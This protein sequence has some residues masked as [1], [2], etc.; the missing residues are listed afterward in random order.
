MIIK[1]RKSI[2]WKTAFIMVVF[3][4]LA[5]YGAI[6]QYSSYKKNLAKQLK[7]SEEKLYAEKKIKPDWNN[8][9]LKPLVVA[10]PQPQ[11]INENQSTPSENKIKNLITDSVNESLVSINNNIKNVVEKEIKK[12]ENPLVKKEP[13]E[14]KNQSN[15]MV[16]KKDAP[17]KRV[18]TN[19]PTIKPT[20]QP[21]PVVKNSNNFKV[22]ES[23]RVTQTPIIQPQSPRVTQTPI[24]QP[25]SPRVTQTPIIQESPRQTKVRNIV[26]DTDGTVIETTEE[27]STVVSSH[28]IL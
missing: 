24:I 3:I 26:I 28:I 18:E 7:E 14:V 21:K 22:Y 15:K 8:T 13:K 10:V 6:T 16:V 12:I 19:K 9:H 1:N 20:L 4:H 2:S 25:Q 5:G 27:I 23:P 11:K 17:I